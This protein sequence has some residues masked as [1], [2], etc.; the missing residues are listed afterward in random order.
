MSTVQ[1]NPRERQLKAL[2]LDVA[3]YIDKDADNSREPLV[4]RWAGGWVRDKL[5]GIQ[6]HDIDT[7]INCMTGFAFASKM[8]DFCEIPENVEKHSIGPTDIGNLHKIAQNPEKSKH[9]ETVTTKVFGFDV[10]FVNLRKETY[11]EDSRNPQME[12]GTAQEDALRRDATVNALFYNLHSGEVEDL[13][14]GLRDMDQK[15]IRTPMEPFQTFMDDPL[16]VLRLVRFASRLEFSIDPAAEK[17]MGDERVLNALRLKISRERVGIEL[18]KMLKGNHPCAALGLI[19]RL[20]LYHSIFTDPAHAEM[21]QPDI[22]NWNEVYSFLDRLEA[23]RTPGSIHDTLIK[24]DEARHFAWNL[25]AI[26]PWEQIPDPK[27]TKPGKPPLPFVTVA[28]R[29]GIKA[30]NRLSDLITAAHKHRSEIVRLRDIVNNKESAMHERDRFG[31]AI[32]EWDTRGGNWRLQVLYAILFDV[33]QRAQK[34]AASNY[35]E[36]LRKWQE[37]LDHLQHLDVLDAPSIKRLV[38]GR[39]LSKGLGIKPGKWMAAAMEVAMAWQLRN[40]GVTDPAG[41]VEEVR[42]R[43]E[44]LG[45]DGV[46]SK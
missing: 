21:S 10:D 31:M 3:A 8:R 22:T 14:G 30:P 37:F 2:L 25:A 36:V 43:K 27:P 45:I 7:A 39:E 16:R 40:P 11:A 20:G 38:D 46:L 19:D 6:S 5:L 15:L 33:L 18:E 34:G 44:E 29:E 41:A 35:T 23:Q 32:R 26:V 4:L 28:A 9:L 12:F 1:L 17:V 13:T 42:R 24:T